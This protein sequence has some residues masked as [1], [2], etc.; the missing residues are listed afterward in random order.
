M[1]SYSELY[2]GIC[3]LSH[4]NRGKLYKATD[5]NPNGEIAGNPDK[6]WKLIRM[7]FD[8]NYAG[9]F[10]CLYTG[11]GVLHASAG[12]VSSRCADYLSLVPS[13]SIRPG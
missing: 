10:R 12:V 7:I 2:I 8:E 4:W 9:G 11:V 5:G 3:S 6:D 13:I 1:P